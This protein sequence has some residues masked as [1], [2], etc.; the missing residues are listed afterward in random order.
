L[1]SAVFYHM[2]DVIDFN[3]D[4]LAKSCGMAN[5]TA[6]PDLAGG[7]LI[8]VAVLIL[9]LFAGRIAYVGGILGG[10]CEQFRGDMAWRLFFVAGLL[11]S[12]LVYRLL[13]PTRFELAV[14]SSPVLLVAAGFL[15]GFGASLADGEGGG[16][17]WPSLRGLGLRAFVATIFVM[18]AAAVTVYF[19]RHLVRG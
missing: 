3:P 6:F 16:R 13:A 19:F 7:A 17:A 1:I 5:L 2:T 15:V 8:G 9:W 4:F 12:P 10:L 14:P 11:L 18:V